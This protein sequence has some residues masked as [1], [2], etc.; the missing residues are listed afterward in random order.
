MMLCL[1]AT[2]LA[3]PARAQSTIQLDIRSVVVSYK[4]SGEPDTLLISGVNFGSL[5]GVVSLNGVD[6]AVTH[7]TPTWIAATVADVVE[8]GTY[9]LEVRRTDTQ[10][11]VFRD[12]ADVAIGAIGPQGPAGPAGPQGPSG[13]SNLEVVETQ[14]F[15][16]SAG[17]ITKSASCSTGKRILGGGCSG[18]ASTQLGFYSSRPVGNSW[19]CQ[20]LAADSGSYF[21]RAYAICATTD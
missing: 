9:E 16:E 8:P 20:W 6:Q 21:L 11:A 15:T 7:W 13:N 17:S 18:S 10:G 14:S 2:S 3:A 19:E 5:P 1:A 12:A 4:T